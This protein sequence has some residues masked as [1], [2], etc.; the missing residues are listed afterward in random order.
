MTI[1]L[2]RRALIASL[3]LAAATPRRVWCQAD[4]LAV[5]YP[6]VR[7]PYLTIF[8]Q[9]IEGVKE[10][11]L[12]RIILNSNPGTTDI[13]AISGWLREQGI[14]RAILLGRQGVR[15]AD[16]VDG[17][18][19]V[20]LGGALL[21]VGP[22]VARAP[23]ISLAPDPGQLFAVLK[24]LAPST[25]RVT[26]IYSPAQNQGLVALALEAAK[27]QG[28]ELIAR[29]ADDLRTAAAAYQDTFVAAQTKHDALW[30][31]QDTTTVD[32]DVIIPLVLSKAWGKKIVVLSSNFV[33][34]KKGVLFALFPDNRRYGRDLAN[35]AYAS[36]P[37]IVVPTR[38]LRTA[39][40][41]RT[42]SHLGIEVDPSAFD[43][44]FPQS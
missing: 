19:R 36:G 34:A 17:D 3:L 14:K 6:D 20:V 32:E 2:S 10:R 16:R 43:A 29:E 39:V 27:R 15:L 25:R 40:N 26:V 21:A 18:I 11:S 33:H 37:A 35:L 13:S 4:D 5:V 28:L 42:A 8:Q 7:E 38:A 22:T 1:A 41:V 9:M 30:L 44:V 23:G 12:G 31:P 24:Q